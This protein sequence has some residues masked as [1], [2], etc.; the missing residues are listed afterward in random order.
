MSPIRP[1]AVHEAEDSG[2]L[3]DARRLSIAL[4]ELVRVVQ[5]RD[6][7]RSCC[8][9]ISVSQC[10]ALKGIADEGAM[11]IN[12]LAAHLYLDKSTASRVANGLVDKGL[13]ARERD[14][15]DGRIVRL[16][17]TP[18]GREISTQID[19]DLATE[20]VELLSDFDPEI[21]SAVAGIV[22][23]LSRSFAAR[24]DASGG[25]CCVVR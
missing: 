1:P 14:S 25:S 23:R 11:T 24:V 13:L 2:V 7:D 4:T 9:G 22:S 3:T 19:R 5:F 12:S 10:Y 16:V 15:G 8:Y 21:R 20:F 17:T 18:R 6:R